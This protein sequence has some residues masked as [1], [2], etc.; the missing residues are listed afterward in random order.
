MIN[1]TKL[2]QLMINTN[3]EIVKCEKFLFEKKLLSLQHQ[4]IHNDMRIYIFIALL[5]CTTT[6]V[7]AQNSEEI[8]QERA[9]YEQPYHP[10][11]DGDVRIEELLKQA[12]KER[13]KLLVQIG[14]NWCVWCLRFNNLVTKTPELKRIL[15]KKYIYY[16]LNFSP[17][18]KNEKAFKKYGNPG[19]KFGYPAFLILDSDG[20]VLFT[21]KSED[22]EE[23]KG[24]NPK[25]V[26]KF[27]QG[28]L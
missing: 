27:L 12:K 16:H 18:N 3:Y 9:G 17:E 22:L 15:D 13:K 23:G 11:E 26:K 20:V 5:C 6:G 28:R 1:G 25:K 14:G 4:I 7:F 2:Q 8:N 10:E 21:Q 19:A 24:Y